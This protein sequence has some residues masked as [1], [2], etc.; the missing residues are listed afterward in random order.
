VLELADS[1]CTA[2]SFDGLPSWQLPDAQQLPRDARRGDRLARLTCA[3]AIIGQALS[4]H[5][6]G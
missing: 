5:V 4:W 3:T 1:A 6:A 2:A